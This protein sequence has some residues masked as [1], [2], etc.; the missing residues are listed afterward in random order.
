MRRVLK[1][2]AVLAVLLA[3]AVTAVVI[4]RLQAEKDVKGSS[5]VEFDTTRVRA[6][7]LPTNIAWPEYGF[8]PNRTRAVT[9]DLRPPYKRVWTYRAGSLV[10]F[11]PAIGYGRLYFSTNSGKFVA[12][13][14]KTGKRAWK[15]ISHR[16]VA[17]SPAIGTQ[18]HGTIYAVFLNRPPCNRKKASD[19]KVIAFAAGHGNIRWQKT[20]GPSESS[21]LLVGNRLYTGDW[22]GRIWTLDA[23]SGRTIWRSRQ[24]GPIKGAPAFSDGRLYVGSYDGHMYCFGAQKGR[25]I[26]KARAQSRLYGHA[27]FYSTPAVAYGRVYIGGTDGK[28]YS[29]GATSGKLRWSHSTGGYVYASPAVWNQLVLVGS[30]SKKF[31][32]FD[33]ATGAER[34]HFKANGPISGSAVVIGNV[35]YFATLGKKLK[36]RTYALNAR[37]GKLL[38]S[39]PDGKYTPAVAEKGRFFLI[40]Y[41]RVYG[42][43]ER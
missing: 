26:W 28:V 10:E 34:W 37:T 19:G 39:Y 13:N 3:G 20:I 6:E 16:C 7:P 41:A 31:F 8:E 27:R 25:L 36:G 35:V 2:L 29:Y 42:M 40:G 38:W 4:H 14:T 24:L 9:L 32:A 11:P 33:A 5:T 22:D 23:R 30:Y 21:P 15:Y 17:A 12:V 18:Q 1:G 43:V